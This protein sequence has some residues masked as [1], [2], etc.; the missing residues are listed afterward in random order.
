MRRTAAPPETRFA[1]RTSVFQRTCSGFCDS[2]WASR[3][4]RPSAR[5]VSGTALTGWVLPDLKEN[6]LKPVMSREGQSREGQSRGGQ[7]LRPE[8][9][10]AP[11]EKRAKIGVFYALA[12]FSMWGL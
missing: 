9:L 2:A 10:P 4:A 12:A 7:E 3:F 5:R 6:R 11:A 1:V 8:S